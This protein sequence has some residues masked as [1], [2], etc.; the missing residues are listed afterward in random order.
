MGN[1]QRQQGKGRD[2]IKLKKTTT[3]KRNR[4]LNNNNV[5]KLIG[6]RYRS[7]IYIYTH[8]S[9]YYIHPHIQRERE[10]VLR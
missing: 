4:M 3:K 2:N 8:V 1:L 5:N 6:K 9:T 7:D 10:R